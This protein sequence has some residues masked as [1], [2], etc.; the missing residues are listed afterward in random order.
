MIAIRHYVASR[1]AGSIFKSQ[2]ATHCEPKGRRPNLNLLQGREGLILKR[3]QK[4][5]AQP[6][7]RQSLQAYV[8]V[9]SCEPQTQLMS[10]PIAR[11]LASPYNS[12]NRNL[13]Q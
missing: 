9:G 4:V 3:Q 1:K 10:Q 5:A 13:N 2:Q 6:G 12:L 8:G 7:R 11:K